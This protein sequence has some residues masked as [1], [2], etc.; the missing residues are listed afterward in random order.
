MPSSRAVRSLRRKA[1]LASLI[2]A[3]RPCAAVAQEAEANVLF[4]Q[5]RA[6]MG[7]KRFDE[8]AQK[9]EHSHALDPA[10]GTLLNLAECYVALGRTASAWSAFRDASGLAAASKQGDRERYA[11]KR[12]KELEP[13]LSTL[14]LVVPEEARVEGLIV[15]R[16]ANMIPEA[17]WGTP[18][19]VDPGVIRLDATAPGREPWKVE[20]TVAAR[21]DRVEVVVP[22]LALTPPKPAPEPV[23]VPAAPPAPAP[24]A[25]AP[26]TATEPVKSEDPSVRTAAYVVGG[27]GLVLVGAG[28]YF[29]VDSRSKF[30]EA[31]CPDNRCVYGVG[32]K[33]LHDEGRT[34][35]TVSYV[36]GGAGIAALAIGTYLFLSSGGSEPAAPRVGVSTT[37]GGASL[38]LRGSF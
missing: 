10:V 27:A 17:L 18:V 21:R 1:L 35:E 5:G 3:L 2:F 12:A 28:V 16:D 8:A 6:L 32:D 19:P 38:D 23:A 13:D 25:P 4:D 22:V 14:V 9:F 24:A 15:T 26:A 7:Q 30:D 33:S 20:R 11:A 29:F 34:L 36:T 37:P 31:N